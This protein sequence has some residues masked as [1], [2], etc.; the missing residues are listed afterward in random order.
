[1]KK[2]IFIVVILVATLVS[3]NSKKEGTMVV[4]GNIIG[5]QK[6]T[7]YLQK[8]NDSILISVDSVK[9]NGESNYRLAYDVIEPEIFYL[10]LDKKENEQIEFFGEKGIITI[11]SKLSKF[12][13]SQSI[14]GSKSNE[15]LEEYHEMIT[16]FNGKRLDIMKETFEAQAAKDDEEIEKLDIDLQ[17]LIKN[18]YRY[19]ASFSIRHGKS[20]VAPFLALTELYDAH[21]TLLDTVNNS[22]SKK[23][24]ASKY[25]VKLNKYIQE[26][27]E[28]E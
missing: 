27:K 3:C 6:G 12:N 18:R 23:V 28:T 9:L 20:E 11:N 21:I 15:I 4:E 25:G 10:T 19:T 16:E 24:K 8:F 1:M 14:S 17:R 7:L 13:T 26:I 5:L 2:Y 22:L